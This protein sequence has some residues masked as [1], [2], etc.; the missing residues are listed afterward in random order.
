MKHALFLTLLFGAA[1]AQAAV[2]AIDV[3]PTGN[4]AIKGRKDVPIAT[5][6]FSAAQDAQAEKLR[7]DIRG[8]NPSDVVCFP[9][10]RA[11]RHRLRRPPLAH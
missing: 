9:L 7:L 2:S 3:K 10:R 1:C 6:T 8:T 4:P 5:V 11:L